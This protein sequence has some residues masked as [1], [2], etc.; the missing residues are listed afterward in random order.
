MWCKACFNLNRHLSRLQSPECLTHTRRDTN[1]MWQHQPTPPTLSPATN[2]RPRQRDV[3]NDSPITRIAMT[4]L[5]L[6][7]QR[8]YQGDITSFHV[9]VLSKKRTNGWS[10]TPGPSLYPEHQLFLSISPDEFPRPRWPGRSS[11]GKS[12]HTMSKSIARNTSAPHIQCTVWFTTSC[13]QRSHRPPKHP[14]DTSTT[15][16]SFEPTSH[17]N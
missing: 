16:C 15:V 14:V 13:S 1:G 2:K 8:D 11:R 12:P 10:C 4:Q 5:L 6:C 3:H 17:I 7:R 9:P